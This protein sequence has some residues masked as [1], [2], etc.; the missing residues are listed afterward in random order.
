MMRSM[1]SA[2]SG[3]KA[4]QTKMDVIG[5]N[6]AN[7]NTI[8]YKGSR[9]Q[10]KE[11]FSQTLKGASSAEGG[12]GGSN[13]MQVGLGIDVSSIDNFQTIG[14]IE[15]T[16]I[17]TDLMIDG[18]GFFMVSDDPSFNNRY[19]TRA[20][21]FSI[22]DSGNLLS[23]G[24]LKVLGY[25]VKDGTIG[26]DAQLNDEIEGLT[27]SKAMTFPAKCTGEKGNTTADPTVKSN[28]RDVKFEGNIDANTGLD[29]KINAK[30]TTGDGSPNEWRIS[31]S[32]FVARQTTFTVYDE[33]GGEHIVKM[34]VKRT[35]KDPQPTLDGDDYLF[36]ADPVSVGNV[37]EPSKWKV[38]LELVGDDGGQLGTG[39][40][41][42]D[43]TFDEDGN[44]SSGDMTNIVLTGPGGAGTK[45]PNGSGDFNFNLSFK[46]EKGNSTIT[47]SVTES[48]LSIEE[49]GGYKQGA[50]DDFSIGKNGE[51]QG[52]FT[53]GQKSVL[54]KLVLAKFKNP[55]GLEKVSSN[56]YTE[57]ANSG[58]AI[59]GF[60]GS[61][62]FG[63]TQAGALEMS[64]I[65]LGREF[66]NMIQTQRGFQAN[67]R[68][69][70][71]T[72][73]MLEELI[74]LKR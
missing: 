42:F 1:Y 72:D 63:E 25:K 34:S 39:S 13:P 71:T 37:I 50:L 60:A 59:Q 41:E 5:N 26:P 4:H 22:D 18:E 16:E 53:N 45:F 44:V 29:A 64:N 3:L 2:I 52:N 65:D 51:I 12:K 49:V 46:D 36:T 47:Q 61:N 40:T 70:N 8:A 74:N 10:F 67:S 55:S 48:S 58:I 57:T 30:D 69:I 9:V 28:A 23:S 38:E 15:R 14:S 32:S 43:L 24:S 7:V 35:F 73:Q 54:G 20:G 56:M 66:T 6:I 33:M 68:I 19:Y 27:I 11:V 17:P 21:N 62:G 31:K